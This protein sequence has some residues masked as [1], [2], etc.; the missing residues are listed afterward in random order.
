M[1]NFNNPAVKYRSWKGYT[2]IELMLVVVIISILAAIALPSY[3]MYARRTAAAQ[4]QQEMLNQA[5][6]LE[7]HKARNFSYQNFS[8]GTV[9]LP[10]AYTLE[11]KDGTDTAKTLTQG[12]GQKWVMK[13]VTTDARNYNFL[14]TSSGKRCMTTNSISGYDDCG[15]SDYENW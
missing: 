3:Q 6:Q 14:M 11:L 7:R 1:K 13:A 9:N 4:M 2:L 12:L 5:E 10:N 15:L 8:M